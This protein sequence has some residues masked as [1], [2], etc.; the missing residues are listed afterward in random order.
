MRKDVRKRSELIRTFLL[1]VIAE[2]AGTISAST[3]RK[4]GAAKFGISERS[5]DS[6]IKYLS[7]QGCVE[8][9]KAGRLRTCL[10]KDLQAKRITFDLSRKENQDE[11]SVYV[12][13]VRPLLSK[14][15]GKNAEHILEHCFTEMF[16]NVIDHASATTA[17]VTVNQTAVSTTIWLA[18]DGIGIFKKIKNALNLADERQSLL[19]LSKGKFTTDPANHSGEGIFFS[20]RACDRFA[21]FSNGLI[22]THAPDSE[23]GNLTHRQAFST[24]KGTLVEMT[25]TNNTSTTLRD[26]F[27]RFTT[28]E[29]GFNK[30]EI[31][32]KL[33]KIRN[34]RLV[35][36]SQAKRLLARIENF[37]YVT[38]DFEHIESIGQAFADQIFRVFTNAHPDVKIS[39]KNAN[40]DIRD[41][42]KMAQRNTVL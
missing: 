17:T 21:I 15:L 8:L 26:I 37:Q 33:L 30:T 7:D 12:D 35:A 23:L 29:A 14:N 38:F 6:H 36:R 24:P 22:F 25:V 34:E 31:P 19:E 13:N 2:A 40:N 41:V 9:R 18:D 32:V 20:S 27:G 4:A 1:T 39:V 28:V 16:N 42:I 3:L 10:L 5:I 11:M